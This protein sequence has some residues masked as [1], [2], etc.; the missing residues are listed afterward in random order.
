[1]KAN[2]FLE[3]I[4]ERVKEFKD[5][6][7]FLFANE[8]ILDTLD[9]RLDTQYKG[10]TYFEMDV[11]FRAVAAMLQKTA[12]KGDRVLLLH[13]PGED[14]V[15]AFMG[16]LYAGMI[17]V[18]IYPPNPARLERT[19]P[20]FLAVIKDA[21]P[22]VV[23]TNSMFREAAKQFL[24]TMDTFEDIP[25]LVSSNIEPSLADDYKNHIPSESEVALFQ[26]TSGSTG[27]PRGVM[28]T[29]GNLAANLESIC[30]DHEYKSG[31]RQVSWLPPYHDLGLI[32]GIITPIYTGGTCFIMSPMDFLK[33][34]NRWIQA[35][36]WFK[37]NSTGG[38]NFGYDILTKKFQ[39]E[40]FSQLDLSAWRIAVNGAEPIK[41]STL[42]RF[43]EIFEPYGFQQKT[44]CL[45]YGM[46]EATN[47]VSGGVGGCNA[48]RY[49]RRGALEKNRKIIEMP[50]ETPETRTVL[51]CG[52][53]AT[54]LDVRIVDPITLKEC[55]QDY[56]GEIWL[57][58]ESIG[59]GY[60]R[61]EEKTAATFNAIIPETNEGGFLR[62]GDYGF[63]RDH[64]IFIT[65]RLKDLIIVRGRN[66]HP[67]D[68]EQTVMESHPN[69]ALGACAAFSVTDAN[70]ERLVVV[71]EL[72]EDRKDFPETYVKA[73][74]HQASVAVTEKH[75]IQ[76]SE[77]VLIPRKNIHKTGSGKI[78]RVRNFKAWKDNSLDIL[79]NNKVTEFVT[80]DL[81]QTPTE[82]EL[83]KIWEK[84]L[85]VAEIERSS[86]FMEYGGD[87]ISVVELSSEIRA[88][89]NFPITPDMIYVH[90]VLSAQA[91]IIDQ[92]QLELTSIDL[93]QEIFL[94]LTQE[95]ISK[96][97]KPSQQHETILLTGATGFL[98]AY[99]LNT[100]VNQEGV[101]KVKVL[102]R[103]KDLTKSEK[104]LGDSFEKYNF[105]FQFFDKIELC[106]GDLSRPRLGMSKNAYLNLGA[107]IDTIYH[108]GAKVDWVQPYTALRATNV[109]GTRELIHL[110]ATHT[111]KP[112][113]YIST[114][115]VVNSG[116]N[117]TEFKVYDETHK[118]NWRGLENGYAQSKWVAENLIFKA[119][120]LGIPTTS[121]R[122]DFIVGS[123]SKGIIPER[124]FLVR[125]VQDSI[126]VGAFPKETI[127]LDVV[128]VDYLAE[129]IVALGMQKNVPGMVFHFR[130]HE[131]L[132]SDIM[133]QML[134][135][136][137]HDMKALPYTDWVTAI[138]QDNKNQSWPLKFFLRAYEMS[139]VITNPDHNTTNVIT[140]DQTKASLAKA[141]ISPEKNH[142]AVSDLF[143]QMLVYLEQIK[144]QSEVAV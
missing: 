107:E 96:L 144:E 119:A 49:I 101:K 44:F 78:S 2:S 65:G 43:L 132:S 46:S 4:K 50:H 143:K 87:S 124:D 16:C 58:G 77:L 17:A 130:G 15:T 142:P 33:D 73:M 131:Q 32:A 31:M 41:L 35:M 40:T 24:A 12:N 30:I 79:Y 76:L 125:L 72:K 70:G 99:L 61:D 60:W 121:H 39:P 137:G 22:S 117:T 140:D 104:R 62:T 27:N 55:E 14:F 25:I 116:V 135:E 84:L 75:G 52:R 103:D 89:F 18:P 1:M 102:T 68:I 136:Q 7:A 9:K 29:H 111:L 47:M 108:C 90:S 141:Q 6:E 71:Q 126:K 138:T 120:A 10:Y 133:G 86:D 115:W 26:Y 21:I 106:Y 57:R 81:P 91:R 64:Q 28:L 88:A 139:P 109:D 51:S 114:M 56:A 63:I 123:A 23:L 5:R 20:H 8:E 110:A 94:N 48:P 97:P 74:F 105:S 100:L 98:G 118:A 66:Y 53:I 83:A 134:T 13:E 34:P 80:K 112:L 37:A 19:L 45:S 127:Y 85:D 38:P 67:E 42:Q 95:D 93:D 3:V 59:K 54:N 36:H 122:M 11:K 129:A 69:F 82:K 92:K 128:A 113:H